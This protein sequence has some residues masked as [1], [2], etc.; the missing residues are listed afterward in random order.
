[1]PMQIVPQNR[2]VV[3]P[4]ATVTREELVQYEPEDPFA[5]SDIPDFD[6]GQIMETIEKENR[7]SMTQTAYDSVSNTTNITQQSQYVHHKR[8]PQ[9]PVFNNC[10]IGSINIIKNKK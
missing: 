5:G 8:S 7:I 1:M 3:P 4:T 6:L 2:N 9:I 10:K